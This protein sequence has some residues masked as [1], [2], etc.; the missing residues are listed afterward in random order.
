MFQEAANGKN[1]MACVWGHLAEGSFLSGIYNL[2]TIAHEFSAQYGVEFMYCKDIEAMRLWINPGDMIAPVLSVNE[3]MEGENIRFIIET[4]GPIFQAEEPFIAVKTTYE[5]YQRLSCSRSGENQ[6][7]TIDV[8]PASILA[9]AAVA[10]CDSVG[11]QAKT[12]IDYVPD[13]IFIDDQHPEFQEISGTWEDYWNGEL[14]DL[15]ARILHGGGTVTITPYIEESRAYRISFHG[16]GSNSN[17]VR[18]IMQHAS[19]V[20]TISFNSTLS[21]QDHWQ[22][23]GVFYLE[24]GMGNTLTIENLAPNKDLGLDVVRFTPLVA[25][26]HAFIDRDS[27]DFGDVSVEDTTILYIT[28]GNLGFDVLNILAMTHSGNKIAI[29]ADFP[30]VLAPTETR[31]IPIAFVAQEYGEY[32]D[33]IVIHTDD[34][35]HS[36]M[37]VPV[38]ANVV[39]YFKVADNDDPTGYEEFGAQWFTSNATAYGPSSRCAWIQGNGMHADFTKTL[40][41]SDVYDIQFIVPATENAHDHADYIILV[42]GSPIDTVVVDQNLG[43]GQFVSIG[44]YNLP[45]DVPVTVRIQDNGGNTNTSPHG[46]VLRADAVRFNITPEKYVLINRDSLNFGEV[47]IEDTAIQFITISNLGFDA[48]N[49]LAMTHSGDKIAIEADFPMVLAPMETREISIAFF[50]QEYGEYDDMIIIQTD[51]PLH[52][53]MRVPVYASTFSY[54]RVADNDDSSGY[55]EFGAEWFSINESGYGPSSRCVWIQGNGLHADFTKTLKYS[56]TYNIQF[57]VPASENAH[58]HADYIILVDGSPI[59]TVVVDQNLKSGQFVSIGEY[60]LPNDV[61]VT[62]RIQDNGGNTNPNPHIVL[63]ADAVRFNLVQESN[64]VPDIPDEFKVFQN[65]PNPFNTTTHIPY[66]LSEQA[67]IRL[68]IYDITGRKIKDWNIQSQKPGWHEIV[69][70]GTNHLQQK[71]ASGIYIYKVH[72]GDLFEAKKMVLLK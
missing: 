11:N 40:E 55:E 15:K 9:K 50:T 3:I 64:S 43:S 34:P 59:D 53:I 72:A 31:E 30:M 38:Y 28:I 58:D 7:E 54:F 35:L 33:M 2:N 45:G 51:N 71:V 44:E 10:V 37:R 56:D 18:Y 16:P 13:D 4:D 41:Y 69:W 22:Q 24:S 5:T 14:W 29:E 60:N 25:K 21:G 19:I 26:K 66:S 61:P 63:H 6:W 70:D 57:I 27:L 1:Q 65:Y 32:D 52:S 8:I 62:V 67:D 12:H 39:P 49:I 47:S 42:D 36:M 68:I 17:S 48:L 20:D 23:I 46:I